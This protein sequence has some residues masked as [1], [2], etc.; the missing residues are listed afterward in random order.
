M[1]TAAAEAE[2]MADMSGADIAK[3]MAAAQA[4]MDPEDLKAMQEAMK[5]MG[6][7]GK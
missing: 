7:M 6:S 3:A 2:N 4:E 5:Q 1:K